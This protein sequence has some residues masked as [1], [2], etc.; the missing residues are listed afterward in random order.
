[1]TPIRFL[2]PF[3]RRAAVCLLLAVSAGASFSQAD[4]TDAVLARVRQQLDAATSTL[5]AREPPGDDAL[6]RMRTDALA[7]QT[8]SAEIAERVAPQLAAIEARIGE[9]GAPTPGI[10]EDADIASQRASL[11]KTRAALDA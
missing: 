1:M 7:A 8:Q 6:R 11:G 10:R 2:T 9:I 4:D 5:Q 3:V